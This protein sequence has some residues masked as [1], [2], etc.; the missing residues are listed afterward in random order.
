MNAQ[1]LWNNNKKQQ[2]K[3][4][5]FR[6]ENLSLLIFHERGMQTLTLWETE[7][8]KGNQNTNQLSVWN[9]QRNWIWYNILCVM[10]HS[11]R[12]LIS[13]IF[14]ILFTKIYTVFMQYLFW[15]ITKFFFIIYTF[16]L[17]ISLFKLLSL[18]ITKKKTKKKLNNI[19]YSDILCF[20]CCF[21][22]W[23]KT[24]LV[25]MLRL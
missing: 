24:K 6:Y 15:T 5:I 3:R 7:N 12:I 18:F 17:S 8:I 13:A 25:C 16:S 9:K 20:G 14:V 23:R 10:G 1:N 19:I 11:D 21:F 2:R 22:F 4:M